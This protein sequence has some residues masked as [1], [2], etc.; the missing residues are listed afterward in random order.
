[1]AIACRDGVFEPSHYRIFHLFPNLALVLVRSDARFWQ[2]ILLQFVPLSHDRCHMRVW[3][4]PAPFASTHTALH[5]WM[6]PLTDPFRRI[7]FARMV[8][9]V[10][11]E[12]NVVCERLQ[13]V[14]AQADAAPILGALEE[15]IGWFEETYAAIMAHGPAKAGP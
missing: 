11:A 1:M 13:T 12:D 4:Y 15:R 10:L 9:K 6:R 2:T 3:S 7:L 8:N 14:A 5:R